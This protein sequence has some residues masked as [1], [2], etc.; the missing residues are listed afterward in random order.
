M[1]SEKSSLHSRRKIRLS[2][3]KYTEPGSFFITSCAYGHNCLFGKI[4]ANRL[5]LNPVGEMVNRWWEKL[6]EKFMFIE[7]GSFV[8]MPNHFHGIIR[9]VGEDP[10]VLPYDDPR[11][12]PSI[13]RIMQWFKTMSTN[14]FYQMQKTSRTSNKPKL[15]QRSYWDHIIR[16][17]MD[18][19][20]ITEYIKNNPDVWIADRFHCP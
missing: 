12:D 4:K 8:V 18:Y 9:I 7:L 3:V 5:C 11:V 14:E 15:W 2:L 17:E 20:R 19:Q 16:T 13:P 6:P 1:Q 10:W